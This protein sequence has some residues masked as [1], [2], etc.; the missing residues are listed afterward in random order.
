MISAFEDWEDVVSFDDE[1]SLLGSSS[2]FTNVL[3]TASSPRTESSNG[4]KFLASHKIGGFDYT[5]Q[6]AYS[7]DIISSI[8]SVGG[9][10]GF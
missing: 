1:A 5:Q 6:T 9:S 8:Y 4:S 3:Y 2:H 10:S 7:P